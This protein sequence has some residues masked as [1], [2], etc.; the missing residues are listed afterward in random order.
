MDFQLLFTSIQVLLALI[1]VMVALNLYLVFR[2]KEIDPFAKWNPNLLNGGGML[3]FYVVGIAA[4]TWSSIAVYDEL[5]LVTNAASE[6]GKEIDRI[7]W[8][9]MVVTIL[10]VVIT[11][12][13]LFYYSWK[14]QAKPG[15]K[16]LF[17]PHNGRLELVWTVIPALVL[18]VLVFDG[19]GV[20]HDIMR[21]APENAIQVEVN[22]KQ[23]AWTFR[24]QGFDNEFGQSNVTY[25]DEGKGNELG[26]N[27]D[28]KRGYDDLVTREL[29]FPV[30]VPVNLNIR[31]RDVL[32]SA[33]LPHFRVKMDAVAGITTNFHFT[34]TITTAEMRE[35][36]GDSTFNF[37]MSC[38]QI[39]GGGHWNMGAKVVVETM[40]EYQTWIA[41]QRTF[42]AT[43]K[44]LNPD[45]VAPKNL[46]STKEEGLQEIADAKN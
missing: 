17:Y 35:K 46:A 27:L 4:A 6:H 9:T 28:D 18:T 29:H 14:Y 10:V 19:V 30:G 38:Q 11:N 39:C 8:N 41:Q 22:G 37:Q 45:F 26:I 24:Y 15:R 34:P 7:F 42:L 16:A 5:M 31:T 33:T 43:Y 25:I 21:P 20:W 23:F 12:F 1:L 36:M 44:E 40:E 13:L 3:M 32:H 2:L